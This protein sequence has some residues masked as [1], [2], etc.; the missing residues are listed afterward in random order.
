[1]HLKYRKMDLKYIV[2]YIDESKI[3]NNVSKTYIVLVIDASKYIKMN[4]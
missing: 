1:M 2:A 3:H 4:L